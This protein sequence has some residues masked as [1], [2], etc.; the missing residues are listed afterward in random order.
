M[1]LP[2]HDTAIV[3]AGGPALV[4]RWR[5]GRPCMPAGHVSGTL[6]REMTLLLRPAHSKLLPEGNST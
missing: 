5:W 4:P 2:E 1:M 6:A 3:A